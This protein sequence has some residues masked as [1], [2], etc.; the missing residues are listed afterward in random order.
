MK[1]QPGRTALIAAGLALVYGVVQFLLS[2]G[3]L[4]RFYENVLMNVGINVLAAVSLHIVLGLAGQFSIGH[5][6]FL[7]VG[8]YTSAVLTEKLG[9][10]FAVALLAGAAAAL[11]AGLIV[12]IPSLRLRG[13]Y[14]AIA[15]L[16]FAE[17]VRII[18]LNVDYV[19]GAA[20][21][22]VAHLTSWTSLYLSVVAAVLVA[23]HFTRSAHGRATLALRDDEVAAAA[24]GVNTTAYKVLAFALSSFFA[25][26][27]GGLHAHNFYV[28]QPNNFGF[29]KSFEILVFVVL[30]GV[31]SLPGAIL[32]ATFLT[33]VSTALQAYPEARM[34]L[35]SLVLILVMLFRPQ[36][37]LGTQTLA[38]FFPAWRAGAGSADEP[39]ATEPH[40][41]AAVPAGGEPGQLAGLR[42]AGS[43]AAG[44]A[45]VHAPP[46]GEPPASGP[47]A[48]GQGTT[49]AG[50]G[51][52]R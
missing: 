45:A 24:M 19:G 22:R 10:P 42:A 49:S 43:Q 33:L 8:A 16:G 13:D 2:A 39:A 5:A 6:G 48:T 15:T 28:I 18:L 35:Y 46:A 23:V 3:I 20:G 40:Q 51:G 12:G 36:G 37:L 44:A 38:G 25:G 1:P 7:A 4:G 30:G 47:G 50:Q 21:M 27:A 29:L 9:V 11:V 26:L 41:P 32:A 17:I 31:G 14:L 34:I 52:A